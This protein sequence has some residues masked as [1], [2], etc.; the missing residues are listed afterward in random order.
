MRSRSSKAFVHFLLVSAALL[1][2]CGGGSDTASTPAPG[3]GLTPPATP[4]PPPAPPAPAPTPPAPPP[5]PGVSAACA[6]FYP[7]GFLLD[8][9]RTAISTATPARPAKGV[10]FADPTYHTCITRATAHTADGVSGFVRNDYSRRQAFNADSTQFIAYA[11]N[12]AW[13][14]Y[15]GANFSRI[16][17]LGGPSEIGGDAE[18]QW[19]PSNPDLLYY[20]PTNGYGMQLKELTVSTNTSRVV[21][22]FAARLRA[23]WPTATFAWTKS[24]GSPSKDGRYWCMM[25]EGPNFESLGVFTWDRNTDTILGMMNTNGE[26]PDHVSMSPSG[27]YCVLSGDTARGTV[28]YSRDFSTSR[29]LLTK[30]EH[31]DIALDEA[32]DD[33]YVSIDYSSAGNGNVFMLNVRTGVRTDLFTTYV[34]GSTTAVHFSGKAYDKPGWVV[35]STYGDTVSN[36][37]LHKKVFAIQLKANPKV[38]NLG[39]T[40]AREL[41]GDDAYWSEPHATVNRSF[42]KILFN[43]TWGGTTLDTLDAYQIE[44]P[45]DALKP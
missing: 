11:L 18:L 43:S 28:A 34:S 3:A 6:G 10:A 12:G 9:T 32:G 44:I 37:W 23:R 35:M 19:H 27:N 24:E 2:G 15:N 7:S 40:R 21:G 42:T 14:L 4:T 25:A 20:V 22:N 41:S 39:L 26:R 17:S 45:A 31:S 13:H 38:Y 16:K 8:T 33:I 1:S 30:S 36:Q 29:T 5:A